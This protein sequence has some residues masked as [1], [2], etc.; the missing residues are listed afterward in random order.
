[1]FSIGSNI[2]V[3]VA[4]LD[5][6]KDVQQWT[7]T[8]QTELTDLE[9]VGRAVLREDAKY[10]PAILG[11]FAFVVWKSATRSVLGV[12][13]A[14]G[15][16]KLYYAHT[17]S[18]VA[19][20][21]RAEAL[22]LDDRYN[23]QYFAER[24]AGCLISPE[25]TPYQGVHPVLA[26]TMT[27]VDD[28]RV[29]HQQYWSPYMFTIGPTR[30][31]SEREATESCRTLLLEAVKQRL[32][33]ARDV[34]AQLSGGMDSS[35]VVSIAQWLV[36][37]GAMEH[38]VTGTVTYV[39][40]YGKGG[41][42][43]RYVRSVSD[44]WQVRGETVMISSA[45][46]TGPD[47]IPRTDEPVASIESCPRSYRLCEVVREAG[48][49]VLLTGSGGDILFDGTMFFFADW[50]A[51]GHITA[52]VR[53]ML[54]RAALGR[55]SFW[56]LAYHNAIV[57]LLP[58]IWHRRMLRGKSAIPQWVSRAVVTR[59]ALRERT[60][61]PL[62]YQGRF[63]RKY[64]DARAAAV[65]TIAP[66]LNVGIIEES[67]DV[68]HPFYYRPLVEFALRLP[69]DLCIR[70]YQR[71]WVLREAMSGIL[72]ELVRTRVG[73]GTYNG[74]IAW[75]IATQK[76]VLEPLSRNTLLAELGI[77]EESALRAALKEASREQ[78]DGRG[79]FGAV[80]GVLSIEAWLRVRSGRWADGAHISSLVS[81]S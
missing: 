13:D 54:R 22:A 25:F 46:D 45:L 79:R 58:R 69:P 55:A 70:P 9:L 24:V 21:S 20:S 78:D 74:T 11:D 48:G 31:G 18:L 8:N 63:G 2:V 34:W 5:N 52:A 36:A 75:S 10:V 67:L 49:K 77:V 61:A 39:D 53:E 27:R 37:T 47:L 23:V 81:A 19:F 57:P 12:R 71:K 40:P 14:L 56:E 32:T 43:R 16:K 26:G 60:V 80:L 1:V 17:A 72:P 50:V 76:A 64:Q 73:K 15:I 33:G 6:R 59:Y 30:T 29:R 28:G 42:E 41:D 65:S 44:R 68:R 4:R 35:S 3:G 51:H 62:L 38:G 66:S 7:G